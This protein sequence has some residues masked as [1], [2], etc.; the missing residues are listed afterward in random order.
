MSTSQGRYVLVM[1]LSESL[2]ER[3]G[4]G[5]TPVQGF[6]A[7]DPVAGPQWGGRYE[8]L[9]GVLLAVVGIVAIQGSRRALVAVALV[10]V[11][12]TGFGVV[13]LS[14]RSHGV[15]DAVERVVVRDDQLVISRD[16][17]FLREGGAFYDG[18]RH[19]LT[20]T[21]PRQL[22]NALQIARES[23]ATEFA[24]VD[25][26]GQAAPAALGPY[27]RAVTEVMRYTPDDVRLWAST[28][29]LA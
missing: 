15:A 4:T 14:V 22:R 26:I 10:S 3:P 25:G 21:T 23:G 17:H 18:D 5:A 29:R 27:S 19:W 6:A 2:V 16:A 24:L 13:W 28:Y 8:L 20:A 7:A 9:T 11:L 12:V 1:R